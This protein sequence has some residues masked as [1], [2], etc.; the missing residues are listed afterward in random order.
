L[1]DGNGNVI[2]KRGKLMFDREILDAEDEIPKVFR[3]GLLKS[4]SASS[5]SR[6]MSEIEKNQPS[7]YENED[8]AVQREL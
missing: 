8:Q 5:L 3:T 6:L 7:D 2:D 1:I 4:D